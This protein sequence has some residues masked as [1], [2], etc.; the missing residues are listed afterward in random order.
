MIDA[1]ENEFT[2]LESIEAREWL[3]SLDWVIEQGDPRRVQNLL[4]TLQRRAAL[5]KVRVQPVINT[6]FV[7]TIP[8]E[9]QPPYPGNPEIERQIKSLV[10]WNAMA[11]VV[12]AN[13][14]ESGIGGHISTYASA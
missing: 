1:V 14:M 12:R 2:E 10:R 13:K 3:E 6:P 9:E 8:V 4:R 5:S 11:M 7:N